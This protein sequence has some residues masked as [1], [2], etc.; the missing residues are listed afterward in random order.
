MTIRSRSPHPWFT[1]WVCFGALL[2]SPPA[3]AGEPTEHLRQ[4]IDEVVSVISDDSLKQNRTELRAR[5]RTIISRRF[6][7][8]QMGARTLRQEWQRFSPD[9][10]QQFIALFKKLLEKAYGNLVENFDGGAIRFVDEQIKGHFALVRTE[11]QR[12]DRTVHLDYKMVQENGQWQVFD[13][14][15][16]DV[17]LTHNYW[18]QFT[19]VLQ[20]ESI[21]ALLEKMKKS[22]T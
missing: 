11:I 13:L 17:S 21:S 6:N 7:Y 12:S 22:V 14:M 18:R 4:T 16:D 20:E 8:R 10:K 19:R 3:W 9:Q 15:V 1:V 5:L 2:L